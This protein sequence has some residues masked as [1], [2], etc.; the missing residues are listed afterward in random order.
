MD[1]LRFSELSIAQYHPQILAALGNTFGHTV[2][3][4]ETTLQ[5]QRGEYARVTIEVDFSQPLRHSVELDGVT[6]RVAYEGLPQ[7]CFHY[8]QVGH[9]DAACP[10]RPPPTDDRSMQKEGDATALLGKTPPDVAKEPRH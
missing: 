10:Q 6:L 8:G 2:K 1:T 3:I 9:A 7:L 4:D 5:V